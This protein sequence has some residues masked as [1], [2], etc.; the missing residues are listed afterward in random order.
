MNTTQLTLLRTGNRILDTATG[1]VYELIS[2]DV[3][4]VYHIDACER[5]AATRYLKYNNGEAKALWVH[6]SQQAHN[7]MGAENERK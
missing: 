3:V 6:V 7:L 5:G 4:H 2:K 1:L